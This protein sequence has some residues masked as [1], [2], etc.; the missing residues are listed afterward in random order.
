MK[1]KIIA[2][3]VLLGIAM[4]PFANGEVVRPRDPK[5]QQQS[6]YL[7]PGLSE[8]IT[9]RTYSPEELEKMK[10]QQAALEAQ[11]RQEFEEQKRRQELENME[12]RKKLNDKEGLYS[13]G[14][15]V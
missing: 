7:L 1:R 15:R 8:T 3:T 12:A 13:G 4:T 2:T 14:K 5:F 10:W 11:R 6:V 9:Q